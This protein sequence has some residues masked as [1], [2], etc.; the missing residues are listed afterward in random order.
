MNAAAV[1][2][3]TQ[4]AGVTTMKAIV[5][6]SYGDAPE[7]VLAY[8]EV[9]RP[10]PGAGEVLVRV[11]AA[12]IDRGTWHVMAGVPYV[13]RLAGFGVRAPKALNPGRCLAGTVEAVGAGVTQFAPGDEVYGTTTGTFAEF[14][15]ATPARLAIKPAGLTFTEAAAVPISGQTALQAVRD[16][17][18]VQAGQRVLVIGASGGVGTFA[19]QIAKAYGAHVTAVASTSKLELLRRIGADHVLD[20]TRDDFSAGDQRY[21][22]ILDIGGRSSLSHLRRALTPRGRLVLVG[23]MSKGRLAGGMNRQLRALLW[24]PLVGQKLGPFLASENAADL[25]ALRQLVDAGKVAPVVDRTYALSDVPAAIRYML[26]G[27]VQGKLVV[28]M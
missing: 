10:T 13:M 22:V 1:Q 7:E 16:K 5:Q 21:D 26:K 17:G 24:S 25:A 3:G 2:P 18:A 19:V 15:V 6:R 9:P 27:R 23:G 4:S 12:S 11:A 20:Y 14:A 28:T 8:G